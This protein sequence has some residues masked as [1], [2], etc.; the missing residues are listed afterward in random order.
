[1]I[2]ERREPR[3]GGDKETGRQGD[4]ANRRD[5]ETEKRRHGDEGTRGHGAQSAKREAQ[6]AKTSWQKAELNFEFRRSNGELCGLNNSRTQETQR[7][8][9]GAADSWQPRWGD[10]GTRGQGD[11]ERK[12]LS[13]KRRAQRP[14]G[15]RQN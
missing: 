10:T 13:A 4:K 11:T 15:R 9:D 3:G 2:K 1:M 5:G 14:A 6:S 7:T 8:R 12:V